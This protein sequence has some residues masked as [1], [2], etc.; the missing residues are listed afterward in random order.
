MSDLMTC[1]KCE[2]VGPNCPAFPQFDYKNRCFHCQPKKK[3]KKK[4][5]EKKEQYEKDNVSFGD[6]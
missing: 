6:E 1:S 4:Q 3:T 5:I 2:F